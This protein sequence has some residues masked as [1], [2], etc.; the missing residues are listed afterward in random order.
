M[1]K[2]NENYI[3]VPTNMPLKDNKLKVVYRRKYLDKMPKSLMYK[4]KKSSLR[5]HYAIYAF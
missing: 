4:I 5:I 2:A 1:K 3:Y